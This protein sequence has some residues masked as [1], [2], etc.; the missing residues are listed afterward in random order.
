MYQ[1]SKDMSIDDYKDMVIFIDCFTN[2][3]VM[4]IIGIFSIWV[5]FVNFFPIILAFDKMKR[6]FCF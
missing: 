6:Y 1:S 5:N 3:F 4:A 2:T